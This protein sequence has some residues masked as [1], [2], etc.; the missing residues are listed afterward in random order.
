MDAVYL[1]GGVFGPLRLRA[2]EPTLALVRQAMAANRIVAAICHAIWVLVSA[3]VVAGRTLT[4]PP[5]MAVDVTNAGG[6]YLR[7]KA[8]RDGNLITA[9][10]FAYLPEQFRL[11]MPALAERGAE[12]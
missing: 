1:P 8:V 5:D 4:C 6:T 3:G 11:L 7:E 10:Y 12:A 2:H 9:E